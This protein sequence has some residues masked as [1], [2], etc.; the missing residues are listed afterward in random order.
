MEDKFVELLSGPPVK[1]IVGCGLSYAPTQEYSLPCKLVAYYSKVL[2]DEIDKRMQLLVQVNNEL[3]VRRMNPNYPPQT[4]NI[5]AKKAAAHSPIVMPSL[6]PCIF[7]LF[8][9]FIYQGT[10]PLSSVYSKPFGPGS[11]VDDAKERSVPSHIRAW[12]L[13]GCLSAPVFQNAA[14]EFV[15]HTT[16]K[17]YNLSPGLV[18]WVWEN[19]EYFTTPCNT[20]NENGPNATKGNTLRFRECKLRTLIVDLLISNWSSKNS[21]VLRHPN[22]ESAWD[23]LFNTQKSLQEDFNWGMRKSRKLLPVNCYF[24]HGETGYEP[25]EVS[26]FPPQDSNQASS[27]AQA[28][29]DTQNPSAPQEP[30]NNTAAGAKALHTSAVPNR[31]GEAAVA[32]TANKAGTVRSTPS[33]PFPSGSTQPPQQSSPANLPPPTTQSLTQNRSP[34]P[35][36]P[37]APSQHRHPSHLSAISPNVRSQPPAQAQPP[38]VGEYT[39]PKTPA[40]QQKNPKKRTQPVSSPSDALTHGVFQ[41]Q[42]QPSSGKHRRLG[43]ISGNAGITRDV[44]MTAMGKAIEE[45]GSNDKELPHRGGG[46]MDIG[47]GENA[48]GGH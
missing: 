21:V 33:T 22:L 44:D 18:R 13:G 39:V 16:G 14:I 1:I 28:R 19:T 29:G 47:N 30:P 36:R 48:N 45:V 38:P 3:E 35:E 5:E 11:S 42:P 20:D 26:K 46:A 41:K 25:R 12:I 4:N 31:E 37:A 17:Q 32:T 40:R 15:Y 43:S 34:H 2:R 8:L 23:H 10:Y 9:R 27:A 24:I 6:E 7:G